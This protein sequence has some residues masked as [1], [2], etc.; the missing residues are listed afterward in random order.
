MAERIPTVPQGG[1]E[2]IPTMPQGSEERIPTMPQGSEERIPT[3]PH[4]GEER[5]PTMPQGSEERIPTMPQGGEERIPTMPQGSEE[6]IPT[7]PQDGGRIPTVPQGGA[8]G[9]IPTVPQG[10]ADGRIATVPQGGAAA[11]PQ[12]D[13]RKSLF[14]GRLSF[15]GEKGGEFEIDGSSIISND[16]GESQIF[17]ASMKG[18]GEKYVARILTTIT[19]A[20]SIERRQVRDKVIGFL[21]SESR[22][23]DSGI[24]PLT[25]H[26]TVKIGD[27]DYYAEI[28]PF[29]EGGDL[30]RRAGTIDY[31]TLCKDVIP[32]IN[33][34][35]R[36]FHE[37]GFVH[38][39]VKPDN[40]YYYKG[41]VVLGDFGIT[42]DLREDGFATDRRK[43]G[44]LG[45][46]APELMSQAAIKAS[47]YY[48]FGQT[49]WTLYSGEMMYRNLLRIY[50]NYGIEE[51]RNQVNFAM[52]NNTYYGLDE[53]PE[54]QSFFEV[55]IRGLLQYDP[56]ERFDYEKVNRWLSEDKSLINEVKGLAASKTTYSRPFKL[57]G[58]EAWNDA[59]LAEELRT[60]WEESKQYL[61]DGTIRDFI[62]ME[63]FELATYIKNLVK[64]YAY[65][66][67]ENK[68]PYWHDEGL[69]RLIMHLE[70]SR[71]LCWHDIVI[72]D[73]TD[74]GSIG[75]A[76]PGSDADTLIRSR[77]IPEWYQAQRNCND[78]VMEMIQQATE[79]YCG[80]EAYHRTGRE[81]LGRFSDLGRESYYAGASDLDS[82]TLKLLEKP[83][84]VYGTEDIA[85]VDRSRLPYLLIDRYDFLGALCMWGY[86]GAVRVMLNSFNESDY[87]RYEVLFQ[88]LDFN[89]TGEAQAKVRSFYSEYGPSGYITW[90]SRNFELYTISGS[91]CTELAESIK[92]GIPS[93]TEEVTVQCSAFAQTYNA[94]KELM[95]YC[96]ADIFMAKIGIMQT[97]SGDCFT[98][99][100]LSAM[101]YFE[102]LGQACPLGFKF[103]SGI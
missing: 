7:I 6:R 43:T 63:S 31:H 46:Y 87:L 18:S 17:S 73:I 33:S 1:E 40:L 2:R 14:T 61:Y 22:K 88:F 36:Q 94:Y 72:A 92:D 26:G 69:C 11:E 42:C 19:P 20:D 96:E 9:R 58:S 79:F 28:Y 99:D 80:E 86:W 15:R 84:L 67:D 51:Q 78:T 62:A 74:V 13:V 91:R 93:P 23:K 37:A 45:Y 35:L 97:H 102:F 4:G 24:L 85:G 48:S 52:M 29:C 103:D 57:F 60:H 59:E 75:S 90:L 64:K 25:D 38:R 82:L 3:M 8:D 77:L 71:R 49:L 44:T 95:E 27:K 34:A 68:A 53:I 12:T 32:S 65:T 81:W 89:T 101:P 50:K 30:G 21:D 76:T 83:S 39:D 10:G 41:R 98:S 100:K 55:L 56:T 16:S 47:D 66:S 5:I 70:K 54:S